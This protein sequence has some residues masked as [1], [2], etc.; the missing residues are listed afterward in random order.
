MQ[1]VTGSSPVPPILPQIISFKNQTFLLS[2]FIGIPRLNRVELFRKQRTK[3]DVKSI[4]NNFE[5]H[6]N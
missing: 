3:K 5:I 6:T 1:E 4:K 2:F